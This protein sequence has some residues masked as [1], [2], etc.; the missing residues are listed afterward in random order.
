MVTNQQAVVKES[1]YQF[2]VLL[3]VIWL[4]QLFGITGNIGTPLRR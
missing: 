1:Q 2:V 4:L 3:L